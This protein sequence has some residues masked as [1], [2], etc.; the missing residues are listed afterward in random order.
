MIFLL[1]FEI[2]SMHCNSVVCS[3][4]STVIVYYCMQGSI[5]CNGVVSVVCSVVY[6]VI[7]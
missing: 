6:T 2:Y 4:V 3:V 1:C 7:V 5:H